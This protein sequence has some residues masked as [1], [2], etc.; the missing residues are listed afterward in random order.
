MNERLGCDAED[1]VKQLT[2]HGIPRTL[3]K[4]AM[5]IAREQGG[6]TIFA[7]VDALTRLSQNVRLAG[8]RAELDAKIG[9]LLML[10][11]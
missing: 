2:Q 11:A 4:D 6:F 8:D 1:V 5:E 3:V 7:I 9:T 10:A